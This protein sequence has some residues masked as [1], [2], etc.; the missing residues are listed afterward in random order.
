MFKDGASEAGVELVADAL[1]LPLATF[2]FNVIFIS[3]KKSKNP[4]N[5]KYEFDEMIKIFLGS[6]VRL[7]ITIL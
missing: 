1:K 7:F 3:I 2:A 4:I 6:Y 5:D